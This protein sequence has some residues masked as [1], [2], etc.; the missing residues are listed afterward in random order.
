MVEGRGDRVDVEAIGQAH[1]PTQLERRPLGVPEGPAS[2]WRGVALHVEDQR[3][4]LDLHVQILSL[5]SREI[6]DPSHRAIPAL[7]QPRIGL[8][9]PV[10]LPTLEPGPEQR[11]ELAAPGVHLH[12][13]RVDIN[14]RYPH[15]LLLG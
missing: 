8:E 14:P 7:D 2:R 13:G 11:L 10:A 15:V 1:R 12:E 4:V 6:G 5:D 9:R 3:P